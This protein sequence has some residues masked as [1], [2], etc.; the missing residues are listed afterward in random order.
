[1]GSETSNQ[2]LDILWAPWR[3]KYIVTCD[4]PA[5]C[6]FCVASSADSDTDNHILSR[7]PTCF[8]ILNRFPYNNGHILVAPYRHTADLESLNDDELLEIMK[9]LR[10]CK[11]AVSRCMSPDGFNVG[12]NIGS[13][14]GAGIRDHVHFHIVPRWLG[15]TNF[16]TTTAGAKVI[17]Q[18][19]DE[20]CDLLRNALSKLDHS[21]E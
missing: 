2:P 3:M 9:L 1:M 4:K 18:S 11:A 12:L 10:D 17:P 21:Q 7:R 6:I 16:M 8:A 13:A 5:E 19:L 15:D 20:T 14:A